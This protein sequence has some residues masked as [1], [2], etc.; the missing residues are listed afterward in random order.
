[1]NPNSAYLLITCN[2]GELDK[3]IT[4]IEHLDSIKEIQGTYGAYDIIAKIESTTLDHL[5]SFI[6]QKIRT[7]VDVKSAMMLHCNTALQ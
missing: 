1:M 3:V 7:L 2:K 5:Q 4:Q 6:V